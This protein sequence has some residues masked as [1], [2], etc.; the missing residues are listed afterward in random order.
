MKSNKSR[1]G[2]SIKAS[3]TLKTNKLFVD[4]TSEDLLIL[5]TKQNIWRKTQVAMV[6]EGSGKSKLWN[7]TSPRN[8][9]GSENKAG[10]GG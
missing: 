2:P 10:G 7:F 5:K 3:L 4:K 8:A 9:E 6:A 1:P